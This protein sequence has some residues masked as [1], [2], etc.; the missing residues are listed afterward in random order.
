MSN[1]ARG[2]EAE[3]AQMEGNTEGTLDRALVLVSF[4]RKHCPWDRAQTAQT[5]IPHLL[6]ES[7]EV[8]DA[9]RA[10]DQ[11]GLEGELGDL[12]LNLAFQIVVGEETGD[13]SR[14]SVVAGLEEKMKQRHPHLFGLGEREDWEALKA[15]ERGS[16]EGV[17]A[18]L[19]RGL[20]PLLK[21]H[22]IQDRVSGVGFDWSDTR[23]AWEKVQE[24]LEEVRE[25]LDG[26]SE[27]EV[28]EELGDLLFS[29]VNLVRLAG[30]HS[31][32]V[33]DLANRKF[34]RRFEALEALAR[35]RGIILAEAGLEVLDGL[36]EELK[37]RRKG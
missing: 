26:G 37:A 16:E 4:L 32:T 3:W 34:H 17:L 6:E 18:G 19:A 15:R 20:D 31:D 1:E 13:F 35:E 30:S 12:L 9:I 14:A 23:G 8:V 36:W 25:A 10:R 2:P 27:A 7:H 29:V 33:L 28:E 11:E 21:A 24:E 5:L 22:R